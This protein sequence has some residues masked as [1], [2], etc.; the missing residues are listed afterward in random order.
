MCMDETPL[1][2]SKPEAAKVIKEIARDADRIVSVG[3]A[4]RRM[5]ER[6]IS[7]K[8][9][10]RAIR[11]G[12]IDGDPWPD[13]NGN[14]RVTMRGRAAGEEITVGLAIEWRTRLLIIT[15]F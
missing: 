15:V 11:A 9:A 14:W 2:L 7:I 4:R 10:V 8:Q 13:E 6:D 12:Y 1:R 3:H 5:I